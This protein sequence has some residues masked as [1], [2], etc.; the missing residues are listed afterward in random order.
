[1]D[2]SSKSKQSTFTLRLIFII[3][4]LSE[5][6]YQMV[7]PLLP[8]LIQ[9]L[10]P[11][12]PHFIASPQS[13]YS[14]LMSSFTL[15][16]L[17]TA[18]VL[19]YASDRLG[20]KKILCLTLFS[21]LASYVLMIYAY[22]GAHLGLF[23]LARMLGG[24]AMSSTVVA[25]AILTDIADEKARARQFG[26]IGLALTLAM[27]VGPF[28]SDTLAN[29]PA[30]SIFQTNTPFYFCGLLA[31][32]CLALIILLFKNSN[33]PNQHTR[34][35]LSQNHA[36]LGKAL[37]YLWLYF[38][39]ELSWSF[40]FHATLLKLL[41]I[42]AE[43]IHA[44]TVFLIFLGLFMSLSLTVLFRF[45]EKRLNL[46]A[47][48]FWGSSLMILS[49]F[50]ILLSHSLV[51]ICLSSLPMIIGVALVYCS[52]LAL[53]TSETGQLKGGLV[54]GLS[55]SIM[56]LAWTLSGASVGFLVS[57]TP[58]YP[59]LIAASLMILVLPSYSKKWYTLPYSQS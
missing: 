1:M 43:N 57:I 10:S 26:L 54:L 37:P 4:M 7:L 49:S 28:L 42:E 40:Y 31:F 23:L 32:L 3:V 17:L 20:R 6:S 33:Q 9:Q 56:A 22:S 19:G 50:L 35:T 14:L 45:L 46:S 38:L 13:L 15:T 51:L 18:P 48:I 55:L 29:T 30:L 27:V 25:Q 36:S 34:P 5:I 24:V 41:P 2:L 16:V 39:L 47:L 44:N 59:Y 53:L 52:S 11:Q 21:M 12:L 58:I 8:Q